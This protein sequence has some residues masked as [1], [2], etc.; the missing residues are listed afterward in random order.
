VFKFTDETDK[1]TIEHYKIEKEN[2]TLHF[3]LEKPCSE[4]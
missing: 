3:K 2:V 4:I 1:K